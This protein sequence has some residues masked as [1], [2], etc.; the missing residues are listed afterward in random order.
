MAG[1]QRLISWLHPCST[2]NVALNTHTCVH[3]PLMG[4]PNWVGYDSSFHGANPRPRFKSIWES[5]REGGRKEERDSWP[6][7]EDIARSNTRGKRPC[8][9][10]PMDEQLWCA[11]AGF[12]GEERR[13]EGGGGAGV[14]RHHQLLPPHQLRPLPDP[15]GRSRHK[16]AQPAP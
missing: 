15:E 7:Q 5:E 12:V 10:C 4:H 1:G 9:N 14:G 6:S 2:S 16:A 13:G 3:G 11:L 8:P